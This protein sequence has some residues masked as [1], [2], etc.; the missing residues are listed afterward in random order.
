MLLFPLLTPNH[1]L[2]NLRSREPLSMWPA[3][4]GLQMALPSMRQSIGISL[5][6]CR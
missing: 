3:T 4:L 6:A 1:P 5:V 2:A